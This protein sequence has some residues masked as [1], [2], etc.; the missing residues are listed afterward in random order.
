LSKRILAC[1]GYGGNTDLVR[2][3]IPE[4]AD[5][6]YFG[7]AGN[8]GDA[9]LW[10][11]KLG[12][13]IADLGAY[14]GHGSVAHPHGV[15]ITWAL[16]MEG[17]IQVN[18][19]GKRFSNEH[20]GYSEQSMA[21]LSQPQG[22]AWCLYDRRL[23]ELGSMSPD[24]GDASG[25]KA[26]VSGED[27]G[28]LAGKTG[29]PADALQ[30]TLQ[31][32]GRYAA[33]LETD[34]FGR[35]FTA[36]PALVPPFHAVRV[37]GAL[38]HTQGGLRVDEQARVHQKRDGTIFPN[39]FAGGGAAR[40]V[41]GEAVWGYLSDDHRRAAKAINFGLMYGMSAF[42]LSRQLNIGRSEAQAYMDTYF[43]RYPGVQQFMEDTRTKARDQGYVE[44]L[45]GRRLY[46]PDIN[47]SNMQ[48][49][50]GAERAAINAPMQGTAADII[51]LAMIS[52]DAWLTEERPDA[53][54]VMQVHDELVF[55]VREDQLEW[56]KEA[57]V[58]R[59]SE[60]ADLDV[61]LIVDTGYGPDWDTAH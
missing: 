26:V 5:A 13:G 22:L 48:R 32:I 25:M 31:S 55:E 9:V 16:M 12:A 61:P 45:F 11:E 3:H 51:K 14:Q 49:R 10:G 8:Q 52:V 60:A 6:L 54:V 2:Q 37:T 58:N 41:S 27:A 50:Q 56:L 18:L 47:A 36:K 4:M 20:L 19:E 38:F 53:H 35:D 46:L 42:G 21:V 24:Y 59:M 57:V 39:L 15:L 40:G 43:M 34:P 44:T 30:E 1:N 28:E 33:G 29:L 7:H 17:G 23:H